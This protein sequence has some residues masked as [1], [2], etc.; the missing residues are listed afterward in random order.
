MKRSSQPKITDFAL[1]KKNKSDII[2][3]K[4][5][6]GK[7]FLHFN[8]NNSVDLS[9]LYK[10]FVFF[11][12]VFKE[13]TNGNQNISGPVT[14][15]SNIRNIDATTSQCGRVKLKFTI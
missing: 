6:L 5:N 4:E 3:H 7:C 13:S 9:N 14:N 11:L 10:N 2:E 1:A 15:D 12:N 8:H